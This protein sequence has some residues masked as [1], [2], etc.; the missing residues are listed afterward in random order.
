MRIV[1]IVAT[2]GA[3]LI[4]CVSWV[5][6][7]ALRNDAPMEI[8]GE[9]VEGEV[10]HGLRWVEVG[11]RVRGDRSWHTRPLHAEVQGERRFEIGGV[12][13][14]VED[15]MRQL[16]GWS[17]RST[18][19]ET[20]EGIPE[21]ARIP[22]WQDHAGPGGWYLSEL[23]VEAGEAVTLELI[24]GRPVALWRGGLAELRERRD[25]VRAHGARLAGVLRGVGLFALVVALF[26]F[27]RWL[28]AD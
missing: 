21:A 9:G 2:L 3:L 20:L 10:A 6:A 23:V 26:C 19:L 27:G 12:T 4:A 22:G 25:A 28:S 13:F 5:V 8:P 7:S 11:A 16:K 18:T 24:E 15:P 14:D 17:I 1:W